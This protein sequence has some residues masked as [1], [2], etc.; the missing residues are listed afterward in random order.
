M[1]SALKA[2]PGLMFDQSYQQ[3]LDLDVKEPQPEN[4]NILAIYKK[5]G[6]KLDQIEA[7]IALVRTL[8]GLAFKDWNEAFW[9]FKYS[10]LDPTTPLDILFTSTRR[11]SHPTLQTKTMMWPLRILSHYLNQYGYAEVGF[12][13][14]FLG[15]PD[16]GYG[17]L[18]RSK[19]SPPK[20]PQA[21]TNDTNATLIFENMV[22]V[23]DSITVTSFTID[24]SSAIYTP[25]NIYSLLMN[26]MVLMAEQGSTSQNF[27]F[28]AYN[29]EA[30]L[31]LQ[32]R[33]QNEAVLPKFTNRAIILATH[34]VAKL[35]PAY[36]D[37]D[38]NWRECRWD[39]KSDGRTI[40]EGRL[41]KG[42]VEHPNNITVPEAAGTA[43]IQS[44]NSLPSAAM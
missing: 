8:C 9:K 32:W 36:Q 31:S 21:V 37:K 38:L 13:I 16:L 2:F 18:I 25:Y 27:G 35:L 28:S 44:L 5:D 20:I 3:S 26:V 12:S 10:D 4:F 22:P 33:P 41:L 15:M 30:D 24:Q 43:P 7:S 14:K 34:S 17:Q 39:I 19:P 42:R 11:E 6:E 23:G 40:G 29:V 1:D